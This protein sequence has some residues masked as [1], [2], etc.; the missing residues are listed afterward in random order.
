MLNRVCEGEEGVL[1]RRRRGAEGECEGWEGWGRGGAEAQRPR[2]TGR[3]TGSRWQL[4]RRAAKPN[5]RRGHAAQPALVPRK[6]KDPGWPVSQEHLPPQKP[7]YLLPASPE[8][9]ESH[10]C[11]TTDH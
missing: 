7:N 5:Y 3:C 10:A 8:Q 2:C 6:P 11:G 4:G 9:P 1:P